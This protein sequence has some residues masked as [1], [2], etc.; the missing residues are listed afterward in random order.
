MWELFRA[1]LPALINVA[2][3]LPI[4]Q[5]MPQ[6]RQAPQ[7]S[8]MAAGQ[9]GPPGATGG[10]LG[11]GTLSRTGAVAGALGG[12]PVQNTQG[13]TPSEQGPIGQGFRILDPRRQQLQQ[14]GQSPFGGRSGV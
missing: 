12:G 4:N 11:S 9:P 7:M 10:V 14:L 13:P 2:G 8:Q 1:I 3:P 6:A 5:A